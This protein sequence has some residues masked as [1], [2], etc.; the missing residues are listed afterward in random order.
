[1][2]IWLEISEY[3]DNL[4][5]NVSVG[6]GFLIDVAGNINKGSTTTIT[7]SPIDKVN[8]LSRN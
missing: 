1:M 4:V 2:G 3:T 8:E 5:V 7:L 6:A